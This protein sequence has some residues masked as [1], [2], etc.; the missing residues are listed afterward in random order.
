MNRSDC[1]ANT[2]IAVPRL[3]RG[4]TRRHSKH[5]A[6]R[7]RRCVPVRGARAFGPAISRFTAKNLWAT[8][9]MQLKA[10]ES[11]RSFRGVSCM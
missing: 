2:S 4:E 1:L 11:G 6:G 10:A 3:V 7:A 8:I 5:T 9:A